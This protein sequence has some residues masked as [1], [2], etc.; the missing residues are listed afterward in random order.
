L[1]ASFLVPRIEAGD[2]ARIIPRHAERTM[3]ADLPLD[4]RRRGDGARAD[5]RPR[6]R[7]E[8]AA[9]EEGA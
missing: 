5:R 6:R 3:N 7:F 2:I 1:S 8:G 4:G 9:A